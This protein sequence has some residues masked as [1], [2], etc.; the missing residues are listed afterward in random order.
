MSNS[1]IKSPNSHVSMS[2]SRYTNSC[3]AAFTEVDGSLSPHSPP[4][5]FPVSWSR[6]CC[7]VLPS[8]DSWYISASCSGALKLSWYSFNNLGCI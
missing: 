6:F 8:C 1:G 7:V 5:I 2:S 4:S 3:Q